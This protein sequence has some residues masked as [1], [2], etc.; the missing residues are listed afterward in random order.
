MCISVDT[1]EAGLWF[2]LHPLIEECVRWWRVSPSQV[3]PN[4]WRYLVVF[5][6]ECRGVGII[7]TRDLFMACFRLCKSR[8]GYYLTTRVGFRVSGTS[9]NNKGW[10]SRY[11]YVSGPAWGF[12]LDWS[13]QLPR[14]P[15]LVE[16]AKSG[17]CPVG[18]VCPVVAGGNCWFRPLCASSPVVVSGR[19]RCLAR[20]MD[21]S[22]PVAG[23][24]C[25]CGGARVERRHL[26]S[27]RAPAPARRSGRVNS[28]RD[29]SDSQVNSMVGFSSPLPRRGAG[30]YIVVVVGHPYIATSLPLWLT[31]SSYPS[32]TPTV[33]AVRHASA[34]K[35]VDLTCVRS[36]VRPLGIRPYLC[37]VD[38]TTTG[39]SALPVPGRPYDRWRPHTCI[40][41]ASHVGSTSS[42]GR[43]S[44]GTW[45]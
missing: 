37:K 29:P 15:R 34:G 31:L 25:W 23:V 12:R 6:G 5:L 40:R 32:T 2:P 33:L 18:T 3:V 8:G 21:P 28:R 16:G 4:S 24:G 9:S 43:L 30:A 13:A 42:A 1:P 20:W 22:Y 36:V 38:R 19:S 35:G 44:K 26:S 17:A 45:M 7:P 39:D 11:L 27:G 41:P 10:K 14:P